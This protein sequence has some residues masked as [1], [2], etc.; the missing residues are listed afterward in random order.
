MRA[1]ILAI[2]YQLSL[3]CRWFLIVDTQS[4][5]GSHPCNSIFF[6]NVQ[7]SRGVGVVVG[8]RGLATDLHNRQGMFSVVN[9]DSN[10][11]DYPV[12]YIIRNL[13]VTKYFT[14]VK[15]IKVLSVVRWGQMFVQ[16]ALRRSKTLTQKNCKRVNRR[17]KY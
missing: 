12:G 6:M 10:H 4:S 2:E 7:N 9:R 13:Y 11:Y 15:N 3:V 17:K 1:Y 5:V 16:S 14:V 8:P